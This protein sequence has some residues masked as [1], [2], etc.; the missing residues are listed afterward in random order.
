MSIS[1]LACEQGRIVATALRDD[2]ALPTPACIA[3]EFQ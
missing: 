2:R 3:K 1:Q